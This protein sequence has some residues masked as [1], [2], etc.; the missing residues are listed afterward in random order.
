MGGRSSHCSP[1]EVYPSEIT[2]AVPHARIYE[3]CAVLLQMDPRTQITAITPEHRDPSYI[4][5]VDPGSKIAAL[6]NAKVL[7]DVQCMPTNVS[8]GNVQ[9]MHPDQHLTFLDAQNW[10]RE[11]A[12]EEGCDIL[13]ISPPNNL[14]CKYV[15][16]QK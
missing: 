8:K 6:V 3:I 10:H 13:A 16:Y 11:L 2:L 7:G 15:F 5:V 4:W 12:R 9:R 14:G 1:V